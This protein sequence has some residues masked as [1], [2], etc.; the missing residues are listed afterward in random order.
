MGNSVEERQVAQFERILEE[1]KKVND[2]LLRI[3]QMLMHHA[4]V[5]VPEQFRAIRGNL[6]LIME[7]VGV[8][9]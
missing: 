7:K 2:S 4:Y 1:F 9:P 6:I 5:G 3:E 8:K